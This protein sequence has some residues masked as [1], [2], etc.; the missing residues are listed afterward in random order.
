[1][2]TQNLSQC[3]INFILVQLVIG[4]EAHMNVAAFTSLERLHSDSEV[5]NP[6]LGIGAPPPGN[7]DILGGRL[8]TNVHSSQCDV[9]VDV[10]HIDQLRIFLAQLAIPVFNA[11]LWAVRQDG[12]GYDRPGEG[13]IVSVGNSPQL[14]SSTGLS[15]EK[16]HAG[17]RN[18]DQKESN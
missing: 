3:F 12:V 5:L 15:A 10:R 6:V 16:K 14:L 1:M 11:F 4:V 9:V 7:I 13:D 8:I 18:G 17:D 2:F